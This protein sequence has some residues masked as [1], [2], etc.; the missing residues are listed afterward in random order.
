MEPLDSTQ[1]L[2][3]NDQ[4]LRNL[5]ETRKWTMF[6]SIFGFVMIGFMLI[7]SLFL[8][9]IFSQLPNM[10]GMSSSLFS[11]LYIVLAVIYL[12]PIYYLYKFSTHLKTG[13]IMKS[14]QDINDGFRYLKSHYKFMGV[15]LA[16]VLAFY[17][18]IFLGSMM[19]GALF[20]F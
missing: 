20:S 2:L 6:I 15:L 4:A 18:L 1:A 7:V 9:S 19:F 11:G 14:Q 5:N 3:L 8:G 17:A 12:F 10:Q 16:V 13:I